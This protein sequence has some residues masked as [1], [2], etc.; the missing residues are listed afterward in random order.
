MIFAK[1]YCRSGQKW[2]LLQSQPVRSLWYGDHV[3]AVHATAP[4]I[5]RK[6]WTRRASASRAGERRARDTSHQSRRT[7]PVAR[8]RCRTASLA[9]SPRAHLSRRD[10]RIH[11]QVP[12]EG[13]PGY[14]ASA[15]SRR[16]TEPQQA[17]AGAR[18]LEPQSLH[19]DV[20]RALQGEPYIDSRTL[21]PGIRDG[22]V[23]RVI[24]TSLT[25]TTLA[26]MNASPRNIPHVT[27]SCRKIA[28]HAVPKTGTR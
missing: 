27:G 1:W 15:H 5:I 2:C 3:E 25:A 24:A 7:A 28:P 10:R 26:K 19:D 11:A 12:V 17:S 13:A 16:R 8:R 18:L 9:I 21:R 4:A 23:D 6:A 14:G 20:S 22:F